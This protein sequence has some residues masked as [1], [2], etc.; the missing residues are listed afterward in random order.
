MSQESLPNMY[1]LLRAAEQ[2]KALVEKEP[3]CQCKELLEL[4]CWTKLLLKELQS[5]GVR[6]LNQ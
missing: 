1:R 5:W 2:V 3:E 6:G 4:I